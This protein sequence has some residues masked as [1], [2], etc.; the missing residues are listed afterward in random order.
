MNGLIPEDFDARQVR[1]TFSVIPSHI[2]S[3][4]RFGMRARM[5]RRFRC[6]LFAIN[7]LNLMALHP[8]YNMVR[9]LFSRRLWLI[10]SVGYGGFSISVN[11]FFSPTI[12]TF[13]QK[14]GAILAVPSIRGG[15]EFGEDWHRAG[16]REQKVC[17]AHEN[18]QALTICIG[19]CVRR[20]YCGDV[21]RPYL[22]LN[23]A[24]IMTTI[25][26][27]S[28]STNMPVLGKLR[29]MVDL[30]EVRISLR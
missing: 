25:E 12:L 23:F 20:F 21:G 24:N 27:I 10:L 29:S 5:A 19:K 11:P 22:P 17:C 3:H 18:Q 9:Q 15:S 28:W 13:L 2:Q 1:L 8:P 26:S 16:T 6:L 4:G 30:T 14:Y 7:Q